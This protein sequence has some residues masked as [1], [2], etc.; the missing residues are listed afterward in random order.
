[1]TPW[2]HWYRGQAASALLMEQMGDDIVPEREAEYLPDEAVHVPVPN[3]A[4]ISRPI[5]TSS[6]SDINQEVEMNS[7]VSMIT[8]STD[9]MDIFG[10]SSMESVF[11][12][13][14]NSRRSSS[15]ILELPPPRVNPNYPIY[16][17]T[18][19]SDKLEAAEAT[20]SRL[21]DEIDRLLRRNTE[22]KDELKRKYDDDVRRLRNQLKESNERYTKLLDKSEKLDAVEFDMH[23]LKNAH[24]NAKRVEVEQ[25]NKVEKLSNDV[26]ALKNEIT[27]FR[28]ENSHLKA[29]HGTVIA[30]NADLRSE[31]MNI[32]TSNDT[33]KDLD[34]KRMDE[35]IV[36]LNEDVLLYEN[37]I[38]II[39]AENG[40]LRRR[41]TDMD[42]LDREFSKLKRHTTTLESEI[43]SLMA[44]NGHLRL[45]SSGVP[46]PGGGVQTTHLKLNHASQFHD[47]TDYSK[48]NNFQVGPNSKYNHEL[49]YHGV[50]KVGNMPTRDYKH[51]VMNNQRDYVHEASTIVPIRDFN[52]I[53]TSS[54]REYHTTVTSVP[55]G[56]HKGDGNTV[57]YS[58]N[59]KSSN[60][61]Q[62]ITNNSLD[63][64]NAVSQQVLKDRTSSDNRSKSPGRKSLGD[65]VAG[66]PLKQVSNTTPFGTDNTSATISKTFDELE[67]KLTTLMSEKTSLQDET[68]KLHQ[69]GGKTLKER[70]RLTQAEARLKEVGKEISDTRKAL[71]GKPS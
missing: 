1:M 45:Y 24:D 52:T 34:R 60:Y 64:S 44:E 3:R 48:D 59:V 47:H 51:A 61:S 25:Q 7:S 43:R 14:V 12:N 2:Y 36:K 66:L 11:D 39:E 38:A 46:L 65:V 32:K 10:A 13:K 62:D 56:S 9:L 28:A 6:M 30:E 70:T 31:L 57:N 40:S 37:K 41:V 22:E 20:N 18:T 58:Q 55:V 33:N 19:L 69:R 54:P 63:A 29:A 16:P 4:S 17:H 15:S 42:I 49:L 68:E 71:L 50:D 26:M 21:V 23:E 67:K 53:T 27:K 35:K 5:V 8:E